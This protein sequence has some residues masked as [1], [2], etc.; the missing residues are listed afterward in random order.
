MGKKYKNVEEY[1]SDFS[2]ET[3]ERMDLIRSKIFDILPDAE[4]KISYNIPA[5][6]S[7]GRMF[8]YFAGYEKHVSIYPGRSPSKQYTE[9]AKE[10]ASGKSTLKFPNNKPLP[11]DLIESFIKLR[12]KETQK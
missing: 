10:Y 5:Y 1:L 8:I 2:D 12:I 6:F 9:L 3:R 4:E 7:D 11:I